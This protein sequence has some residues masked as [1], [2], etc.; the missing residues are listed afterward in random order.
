MYNGYQGSVIVDDYEEHIV[1]KRAE[2]LPGS[3][4]D[5]GITTVKGEP[6]WNAVTSALV[7]SMFTMLGIT[8]VY[9]NDAASRLSLHNIIYIYLTLFSY[10]NSV[11]HILMSYR[12]FVTVG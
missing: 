7:N 4:L 5:L 8:A 2:V 6:S 1:V 11:R 3:T 10:K 12:I 9:V